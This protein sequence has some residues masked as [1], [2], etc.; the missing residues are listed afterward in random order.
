VVQNCKRRF[1]TFHDIDILQGGLIHVGVLLD[2][3]DQICDS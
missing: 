2:G 1:K 3:T